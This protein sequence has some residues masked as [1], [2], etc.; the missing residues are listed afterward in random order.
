[1]KW[2]LYVLR[3]KR[4]KHRELTDQT[5]VVRLRGFRPLAVLLLTLS[6][7]ET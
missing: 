5:I 3:V 7:C 6:D 1:M 4:E 2:H